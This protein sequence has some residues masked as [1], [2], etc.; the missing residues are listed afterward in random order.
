M[1]TKAQGQKKNSAEAG[2]VKGFTMNKVGAINCQQTF[3]KKL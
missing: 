3:C 2:Q 1:Y